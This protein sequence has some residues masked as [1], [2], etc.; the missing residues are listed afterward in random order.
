MIDFFIFNKGH[1]QIITTMKSVLFLVLII[2][3]FILHS[4]NDIFD[5]CRKGTYKDISTIYD[6]SPNS[7]NIRNE[8]GYLPLTLASYH[9][10][11]EVVK[12]LVTKVDDLNGSSNYGTPLM[13]AVVKGNLDIVKILL[14]VKVDTNIADVNGTTALHYATIFNQVETVKLLVDAGARID[15][16]D[17]RGQTSLDYATLK[18]NQQILAIFNNQ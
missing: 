5:V 11:E 6:Q 8:E 7:I 2:F 1:I 4:Q 10:N 9:G 12:F 15:L 14:N 16:K 18:G 17:N 13:A 3:P